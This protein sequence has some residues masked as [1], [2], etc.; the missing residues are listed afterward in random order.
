MQA[1][2]AICRIA[3]NWEEVMGWVGF[4]PTIDAL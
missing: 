1:A 2:P 3:I 4:E